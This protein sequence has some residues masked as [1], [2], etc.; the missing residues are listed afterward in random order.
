M[1]E[2]ELK[3]IADAAEGILA[4]MQANGTLTITETPTVEQDTVKGFD[5]PPQPLPEVEK[6]EDEA[7]D[8]SNPVQELDRDQLKAELDKMGVPYS[9]RTRTN[10]LARML[11]KAKYVKADEEPETSEAV[12]SEPVPEAATEITIDDIRN[13]LAQIGEK[14][15]LGWSTVRELLTEFKASMVSDLPKGEYRRFLEKAEATLNG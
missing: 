5:P 14:A 4:A 9:P 8:K 6:V 13:T 10:T 3:R 7:C 1:I 15:D 2:Q 12:E 11:E